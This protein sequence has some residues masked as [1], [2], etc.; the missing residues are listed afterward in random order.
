MRE[1][2]ARRGRDDQVSLGKDAGSL[3]WTTRAEMMRKKRGRSGGSFILGWAMGGESGSR[4]G[5]D[6]WR[7]VGVLDRYR[8][9]CRV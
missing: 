4:G 2:R 6:R 5:V 8:C 7:E 1:R 3:A 9:V